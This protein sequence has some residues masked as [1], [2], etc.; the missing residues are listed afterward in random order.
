MMDLVSIALA[1]F[2][3]AL[4]FGFMKF[5]ANVIDDKGSGNS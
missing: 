1:S 3:F 2:S 5:C 4:F